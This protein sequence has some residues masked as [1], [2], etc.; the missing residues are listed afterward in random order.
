MSSEKKVAAR[1]AM[2]VTAWL[3]LLFVGLKL[4]GHIAWSWWW[5]AAPLW[6]PT[7]IV[8]FDV[9]MSKALARNWRLAE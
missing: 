9:S 7:G 2:G 5:V 3:F 4:T 1:G 6:I 8:V